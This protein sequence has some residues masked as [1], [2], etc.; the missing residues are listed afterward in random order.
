MAQPITVSI[1]I[2][3]KWLREKETN[4][5]IL[6]VSWTNFKGQFTVVLFPAL[7]KRLKLR[8]AVAQNKINME[9]RNNYLTWAGFEPTTAEYSDI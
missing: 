1:E 6:L 8:S 7:S 2:I 9:W 4:K 3:P 5:N